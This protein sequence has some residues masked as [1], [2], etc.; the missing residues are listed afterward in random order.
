MTGSGKN[1]AGYLAR[2]AEPDNRPFHAGSL[3]GIERAVVIPALAE[4]DSLFDTLASLAL[5]PSE[6]LSRTLVICVVN[7]RRR[8]VC[9]PADYRNNQATL[10][11]LSALI[12]GEDVRSAA[13]PTADLRLIRESGLRLACVDASSEGCELPDKDAGVGLAR[14]IG[15]DKALRLFGPDGWAKLVCCLDAD[16]KVAADYLPQV[17]RGF[18][19]ANRPAAAAVA[20]AH[21]RPA[22]PEFAAA[23]LNY[24][25]YLRYY[26]CGL[27]YAGSPYAFHSIG[28]AMAVTAGA[29]ASVRGINRLEAA[30]DFYFLNKLAKVGPVARIDTTRVYPA[31]RVSARVPF[32]T[33]RRMIRSLAGDHDGSRLYHPRIFL[34]LAQWLA[35]VAGDP[36]RSGSLICAE[37]AGIHQT[38]SD[39]LSARAFP[40]TWEKIRRNSRNVAFLNRQFHAWFDGFLTLKLIHWLNDHAFPPV[41]MEE[42]LRDLF[43]A[44]GVTPPA[45]LRFGRTV[46]G[47]KGWAMLQML[48]RLAP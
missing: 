41:A 17:T 15:M 35:A 32:G 39:F 3:E 8:E 13:D 1:V 14:K 19:R 20:Y 36:D 7:N 9:D 43:E 24:E 6:D 44:M 37:A 2:H 18:A 12:R 45:P 11:L 5:N 25:I 16:T 30:E 48:R 42:G 31:A 21:E 23:I 10:A 26:V 34:I 40:D 47:D 46:S 28:S 38:L 29:Y 33:G 27:Q 22:D 4:F